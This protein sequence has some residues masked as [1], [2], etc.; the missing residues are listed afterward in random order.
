MN[1][2]LARPD[3]VP[4]P[5]RLRSIVV[6]VAAALLVP[7]FLNMISSNLIELIK[8]GDHMKLLVLLGF[9]LVAA[10]SST[11]FI[12]TLSDRILTEARQARRDAAEAKGDAAEVKE[13]VQPLMVKETEQDETADGSNKAGSSRNE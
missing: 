13:A 7:L 5:N 4:A 10:I 3:D 8:G 2:Y 1:F 9:C 12:R 6:G 11:A